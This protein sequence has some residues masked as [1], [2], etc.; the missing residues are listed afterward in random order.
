MPLYP[1]HPIVECF[2]PLTPEQFQNLKNSIAANMETGAPVYVTIWGEQI[3]DG[4][5]RSTICDEFGITPVPLVFNGTE[6]QAIRH[7]ISLNHARRHTPKDKRAIEAARAAKVLSEAQ[8][9]RGNPAWKTGQE[10]PEQLAPEGANR[11]G[12]IGQDYPIHLAPDGANSGNVG[13][14]AE[15][16][17]EMFDVS[18]RQVE[19]AKSVLDNGTPELQEAMEDGTITITDAAAIAHEAPEVQKE[20]VEKVKKK[21]ARTVKAAVQTS[22]SGDADESAPPSL[23][24]AVGK[25]VPIEAIQAFQAASD[26]KDLCTN[27]DSLVRWVQSSSKLPGWEMV[28][29]DSVI[30][31]LKNVRTNLWAS[32]ATHVCPA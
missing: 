16:A 20:A 17:A 21:K 6:E 30:Q 19:K 11:D 5:H 3:I 13:K 27:L 2:D 9:R 8:E 1:F 28:H 15:I 7:A 10:C 12:E 18:P 23:E 31:T 29:A 4:R 26:I 14:T 24:D 22:I 32:R 25:P